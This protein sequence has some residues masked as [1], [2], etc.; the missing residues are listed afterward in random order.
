MNCCHRPDCPDVHCPGRELC[1]DE[2]TPCMTSILYA[3]CMLAWSAV[4]GLIV[5]FM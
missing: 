3:G 5:Y 2:L 1:S 4:I